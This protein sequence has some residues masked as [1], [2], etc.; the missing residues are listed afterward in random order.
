MKAYHN[1]AVLQFDD[2][3]TGNAGAG[4]PVTVRLNSTQALVSIF[5]LDEVAIANP[6]TTD[7]KGNYAFKT[8][9][10]VYDIII[11]EGTGDEVKLEKVQISEFIGVIND[12]SQAYEFATVALMKISTIVF[13]LNKRLITRGYYEVGDGGGA[14]YLVSSTVAVDGFGD[15]VIVGAVAILKADSWVSAK[16]YGLK[17]D[18]LTNDSAA[19][20]AF[21]ASSHLFHYFPSGIY[22]TNITNGTSNRTYLFETDCIIDGVVHITGTG[23]ATVPAQGSVT[24]VD[25][26]RM[27]GTV[28]CTVR[29]G[30]F[31]CKGLDVDK[32]TITKVSTSY[33]NQTATGGSTGVH[34]YF[35]T[36]EMKVGEVICESGALNYNFSVDQG[37]I[38]GADEVP[39]NIRIDRLVIN[40][41]DVT[42]LVTAETVG[43]SFGEIIIKNQGGANVAWISQEDKK[44][45]VGK[46]THNGM[47][48]T[49]GQ[50]GIYIN[51][52]DAESN[53]EFG[54]I[55]VSN[56]PGIAFRTYNTGS[57]QIDNFIGKNN[58]EHTRIQSKVT[59]DKFTGDDSLEIGLN[60]HDNF[61]SGSYVGRAII[62]GTTGTGINVG[63]DN[64]GIDYAKCDGFST[65]YGLHIP[66]GTDNFVNNYY[67]G[68]NCSQ[69][70][71]IL[72]AGDIN[73][74]VM[75]LHD[76]TYGIIGSGLGK[77]G[78]DYVYYNNN[79]TD[80]NVTL[81]L[82]AGFRGKKVR[83]SVSGDR[84]DAAV[85]LEVGIDAA[86]QRFATALTANRLVTFTTANAQNGDKFRIS[87]TAT[88][89]FALSSA[90]TFNNKGLAV[91]E[92]MDYEFSAGGWWLTGFG[93]L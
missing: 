89:A 21:S 71:R 14:E 13:P 12:L 39:E 70:L 33:V 90:G 82:S 37:P 50:V 59:I 25:N 1:S 6:T 29:F 88:G 78:F 20:S 16:Q 56:V 67:E 7:S 75:N 8:N 36:K 28:N 46:L 48:A 3:T 15:H 60:F 43:L 5:D 2:S 93:Q 58:R 76:N 31:Y 66:L 55:D 18:R 64:V 74:G 57:V 62:S 68:A 84:G 24:W 19:Q 51:N 9:D 65:L 49:S 26:V 17:G 52:T 53:A 45:K 11:S 80:T 4:V 47:G 10:G 81:E 83:T 73:M 54:T 63:S 38:K 41:T 40:Q 92:W 86:T 35:G 32:I 61:A 77:F 42:G 91:N 44:L 87:R 23:P 27:L 34:L 72:S 85:S 69:G 79:G 22:Q 30:T